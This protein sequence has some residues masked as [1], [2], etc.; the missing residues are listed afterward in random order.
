MGGSRWDSPI[1]VKWDAKPGRVWKGHI[2]RTPITVMTYTTRTVGEVMIAIDGG[3]GGLLP[4]TDVTVT[5]TIASEPNVLS[6]PREALYT[7]NGR[8]YVFK[9]AKKRIA[10]GEGAGGGGHAEPDAGIDRLRL[11]E[12]DAVA[13]GTTTGQP[14][15][16]GVPIKVVQ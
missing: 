8:P 11:Q 9:L 15:Q 16:I 4:D 5:V 7:E 12:G 1:E 14:L 3:D 13:T 2:E 6:V 10:T